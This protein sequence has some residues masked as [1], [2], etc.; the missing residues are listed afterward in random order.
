[1]ARS[2]LKRKNMLHMFWGEA[3][4]YV[5]KKNMP[6]MFWGEAVSTTAYIWNN[7]QLRS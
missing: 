7:V 3:V 5:K 6:H 4:K 2:M 1:M